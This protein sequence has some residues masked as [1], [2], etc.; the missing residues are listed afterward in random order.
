MH[1]RWWMIAILVVV[2]TGVAAVGCMAAPAQT[3]DLTNA[4]VVTAGSAADAVERQAALM[5]RWEVRKRTGL[6]L[7]EAAALPADATPAIVLG[8]R[9]RMPA[10]PAGLQ[11]PQPPM[12]DGKPAAEGYVV[13]VD[14]K[15]RPGPTVCCVGNDHRGTL[16]AVGKLLRTVDWGDG[17]LTAPA[18]LS[19]AT[20]PEYPVRGM[21]LGYRRLNDTFDAWDVGRYAQYIRDLIIFG[22]N[23]VELIPPSGPG[24]EWIAIPDPLMPLNTWDMTVALSA[25]LDA[26]DMDVWLWLPLEDNATLDPQRRAA[27]LLDRDE[28]FAACPRIDHVFVP[29]GDPGNTSPQAMIPYLEELAASL[30]KH[31]P[32]AKLWVSSQKWG[33]PG[34]KYFTDYMRANQPDWLAGM[35]WG[36]SSPGTPQQA[37]QMVPAKYGLRLYPDITHAL[38]CQYPFPY[39]DE[40]WAQGYARQPIQ[41]RPTQYAHICRLVS[42]GTVGAVCYSDGTGDDVNK[43]IWDSLLWDPKAD[44]REVL[45]DYGRAFFGPEF[46]EEVAD[47]ELMLEQDW[48]GSAATNPQVAR[49]FAHWQAMEKR[50]TP[51]QLANWRFQQGLIRA[52]GDMFIQTRVRRDRVLLER[53]YAELRKAP[54]VGPEAAMAAAEPILAEANPFILSSAEG[55]TE[56]PELRNR[57]HELAGE[58]FKSIG[59]QL[60]LEKYGS[61]DGNRGAQLDNNDRPVSD[62]PWLRAELAEIRKLPTREAQLAAIDQWLNWTDPGPGG[63][64]DDLGNHA[65]LMDPHLVRTMP[66]EQ[67]PEFM[68]APDDAHQSSMY[69]QYQRMSWMNQAEN[70]IAPLRLRYTGLDPN[71]TYILK[72]TYGGRGQAMVQLYLE[73][74]KFGDPV[75]S[76]PQKPTR[77]EF[78]VPKAMTADGVLDVSWNEV[79]EFGA[80]IAEAWLVKKR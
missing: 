50:A 11:L 76:D 65:N 52:Y 25:L 79:G 8:S 28:L 46:A 26:Y 29:A 27:T 33:L 78:E 36:P 66:W 44:V 43:I 20:A 69:P 68:I 80:K 49:T 55:L 9:E 14:T 17:I 24:V 53:A 18:D 23:S 5:L 21:Q 41:P 59:M 19:T 10:L 58:L 4:V 3:V 31:H 38:R 61:S 62:C 35:V 39:L 12:K 42:P 75:P 56:A 1:S 34:V 22:N 48:V 30:H 51:K 7:K 37:R 74:K 63:F 13:A 57:I 60:S 73:G 54:Q 71:A 45:R 16:F 15:S 40:P 2:L 6:E 32:A 67:D 64:Y 47:G 70:Y 77:H 72:A